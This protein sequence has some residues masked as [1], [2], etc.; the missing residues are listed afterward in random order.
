MSNYAK[1]TKIDTSKTQ[2][3][4]KDILVQYGVTKFA[5]DISSNSIYFELN[6]KPVKVSV[7]LPRLEQFRY[8]PTK[9]KRSDTQVKNLYDQDVKARWRLMKDYIK[10]SLEMVHLGLMDLEQAFLGNFVLLN[11]KTIAEEFIPELQKGIGV[12][13]EF[14]KLPDKVN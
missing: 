13:K 11:G 6:Q 5:F 1:N 8:T 3:E 12:S 2:N 14:L 4:I 9:Q 10:M 7:P